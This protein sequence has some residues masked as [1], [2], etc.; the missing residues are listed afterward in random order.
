MW[1]SPFVWSGELVRS[2]LY[3]CMCNSCLVSSYAVYICA[4]PFTRCVYAELD[5]VHFAQA[6]CRILHLNLRAVRYQLIV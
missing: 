2:L 1:M 5:F 3:A 6:S 4:G